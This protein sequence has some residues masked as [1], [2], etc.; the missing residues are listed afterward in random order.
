MPAN[1]SLYD[2]IT[3]IYVAS[4]SVSNTPYRECSRN[5]RRLIPVR[6][7]TPYRIMNTPAVYLGTQPGFENLPPVE[8]YNLI[9]KVGPHPV[10]STVSRKTLEDNGVTPPESVSPFPSQGPNETKCD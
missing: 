7:V 6:P 1:V 9:A 10:G 5:L 2:S 8:L 4:G 3:V